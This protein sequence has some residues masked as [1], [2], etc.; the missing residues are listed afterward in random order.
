MT[1]ALFAN[2]LLFFYLPSLTCEMCLSNT[3]N[4][5]RKGKKMIGREGDDGKGRGGGKR[6]DDRKE[7]V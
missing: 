2:I 6:G 5:L 4:N 1:L 7:M 3:N